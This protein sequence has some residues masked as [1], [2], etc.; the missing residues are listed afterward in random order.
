[1]TKVVEFRWAQQFIVARVLFLSVE[2]ALPFYA[3]QTAVH[4]KGVGASLTLLLVATS[5]GMIFAGLLWS[6]IQV[7]SRTVMVT[8]TVLAAAGGLLAAAIERFPQLQ[9]LALHGIVLFLVAVGA[10]SIVSARSLYLISMAP[11]TERPYF[12][13][14][15]SV[16]TVTVAIFAAFVL[17]LMAEVTNFS[18]PIYCLVGLTV[19]AGLWAAWLPCEQPLMRNPRTD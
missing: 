2:L 11:S 13:A 18:W 14:V 9:H 1:M 7:S 16:S 17:G 5:A 8:G 10:V 15:A 19:V 12:I 4:H 6:W 3:I